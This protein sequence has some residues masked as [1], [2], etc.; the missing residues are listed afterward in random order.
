MD[1]SGLPLSPSANSGQCRQDHAGSLR[2]LPCSLP[3]KS[4]QFLLCTDIGQ[5][6]QL[7]GTDFLGEVWPLSAG[8]FST[9]GQCLQDDNGSFSA[10]G[11]SLQEMT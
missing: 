5:R 6:Q 9:V 11:Q 10:V 4:G 7:H 3:T 2:V 1:V 8:S